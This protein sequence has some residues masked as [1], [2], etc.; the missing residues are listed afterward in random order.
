MLPGIYEAVDEVTV[1]WGHGEFTKGLHNQKLREELKDFLDV[2]HI[3]LTSSGTLAI[4]IGIMAARK[5]GYIK[6]ASPKILVSAYTWDS[7]PMAFN[8]GG[9]MAIYGDIDMK[10]WHLDYEKETALPGGWDAV[11]LTDTFGVKA[12]TEPDEPFFVDAAHSMGLPDV[13][14][15][16]LFETFSLA[17]TKMVTAGEGGVIATTHADIAEEA[18]KIARYA[19]R[20]PEASC[21]LGR[22]FLSEVEFLKKHRKAMYERYCER[23]RRFTFQDTLS[24]FNYY[25]CAFR[26]PTDYLKNLEKPRDFAIR[27]YYNPPLASCHNTDIIAQSVVC[28]PQAG[29]K[30]CDHVIEVVMGK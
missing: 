25:L 13:G 27:Q 3:V 18:E 4:A 8:M 30:E 24:G 19:G 14:S 15:R 12:T 29:L 10:R 23:A 28:L 7:V 5:C 16:G 26:L 2:E 1:A 6:A 9:A 22:L 21:A 11:C 20:L 17:A